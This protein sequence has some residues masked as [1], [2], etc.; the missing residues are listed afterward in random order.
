MFAE[1]VLRLS[2]PAWLTG[3]ATAE[4]DKFWGHT[5]PGG[6]M[7]LIIPPCIHEHPDFWSDP[8]AF[9]PERFDP[10]SNEAKEPFSYVPFGGGPHVCIGKHFAML[11]IMVGLAILSRRFELE[12]HPDFDPVHAAGISAA[13]KFPMMVRARRRAVSVDSSTAKNKEPLSQKAI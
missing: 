4:D 1:E 3:K 2:P 6:S 5:V 10:N 11:E 7:V 12:V 8:K 13:P 9:R